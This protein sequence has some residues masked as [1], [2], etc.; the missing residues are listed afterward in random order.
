[1]TGLGSRQC[2]L[3]GFE[4]AHFAYQDY[5]RVLSQGASQRFGERPGIDIDFTLRDE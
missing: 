4:V 5:I 3:D 2:R 1:V